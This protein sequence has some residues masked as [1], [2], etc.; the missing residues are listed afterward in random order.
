MSHFAFLNAEWPD[1][2]TEARRAESL[3]YPDPRTACFY[4]RRTLE[5]TVAWLYKHDSALKLPYQDNLAALIAEPT[6]Q[7]LLGPKLCAKIRIIK[8]LGNIA[9]HSRKPVR[10]S[11]AARAVAELF[12]IAYWLAHNYARRQKPASGL[13]F[14][15]KVLPRTSPVPPHTLKQL[16]DLEQA[17]AANTE[18]LSRD[19]WLEDQFR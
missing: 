1:L 17:L 3:A 12:H 14:D 2:A 7:R 11:D 8:D 18:K 4:A 9:V 5:L 16:Q 10:E 15:L 19:P 6:F 13:T